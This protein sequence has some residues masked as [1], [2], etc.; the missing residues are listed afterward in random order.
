MFKSRSFVVLPLA[1][2]SGLGFCLGCD[3]GVRT[4]SGVSP[5]TTTIKDTTNDAPPGPQSEPELTEPKAE[6]DSASQSK[7]E[8]KPVDQ[9]G[10]QAA[11]ASHKGKVV[12]VDFWAT[13]CAPCRKK[14]PHTVKLF[15]THENEGLVVV[16]VAMDDVDARDD[17][18]NFLK[19]QRATFECVR[20]QDGASDESFEAFEIP[21]GS[22]PCLRLYDREGKVV[23]T[24]AIDPESEKP[25]T[26]EDVAAAVIEAL[27]KS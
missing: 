24:F 13:W 5:S 8:I 18:E 26:D 16:A 9:A 20:S 6:S 22:L 19:E 3:P 17:I 10:L 12:L 11:V 27:K 25:F 21:G 1:I 7:R 23:R 4:P 15:N 14:F 2:A